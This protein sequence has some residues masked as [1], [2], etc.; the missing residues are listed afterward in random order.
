MHPVPCPYADPAPLFRHGGAPATDRGPLLD[1]S[2]NV[3]PLGPPRSV[4][5]A[6]RRELPAIARY[7]D[8]ACQELTQRLAHEH[9]VEPAQVVIG[10][11]S[12]E[13]IHALPR[14]CRPRRAAIAEPTYTEYLRASLLA[15]AEVVHWLADG[16]AFEFEPFD[17]GGAELV[18]LCNPN[19]PTG[20]LWP[21]AERLAAWI[22]SQPRTRFLVD[23]AFMP[24]CPAEGQHSLVPQLNTLPNLIV[25]R[26]LTKVYALP[27]LRLGYALAS[28]DVAHHLRAQ[29]VPWSVNVLAQVAG[30]AALDDSAFQARTRR[31]LLAESGMF[32]SALTACSAQLD[33]LPSSTTFVLLRLR[34]CLTATLVDHLAR[35]GITIRDASNFVGLND[36]YV[37]LALRTARD[38]QRLIVALR[39]ALQEGDDGP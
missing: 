34:N 33:A 20:G 25:L 38:N 1:F 19:N 12:N 21:P 23:E 28:A 18:W 22:G 6:L 30:L 27:G 26:S 39:D 32:P 16:A 14:A 4:L 3:N 37:R 10:N 24:L 35:R 9:G 15:G 31:W 11:G 7:P 29:L 36:R 13:L 8:A 5:Q 17:P 2:V